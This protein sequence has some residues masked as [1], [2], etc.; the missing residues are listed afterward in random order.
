MWVS[1]LRSSHVLGMCCGEGLNTGQLQH[2][3]AVLLLQ[4]HLSVCDE[5]VFGSTF[6]LPRYVFNPELNTKP[7]SLT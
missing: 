2:L 3:C 1:F 6:F 5:S 4:F 7:R